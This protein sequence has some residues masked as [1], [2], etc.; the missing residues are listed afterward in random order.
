MKNKPSATELEKSIELL[1]KLELN[2]S[3]DVIDTL[4]Q[5]LEYFKH[6][7]KENSVKDIYNLWDLCKSCYG[8]RWC[9]DDTV[10]IGCD[11]SWSK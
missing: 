7:I 5:Q 8:Q 10:C 6:D 9:N 3:Y 4:I 1:K 2:C 11:N